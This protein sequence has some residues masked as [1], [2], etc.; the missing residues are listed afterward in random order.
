MKDEG[1]HS[2]V[3]VASGDMLNVEEASSLFVPSCPA[4]ERGWKP[5]LRTALDGHE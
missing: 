3:L 1:N 4:Q 2:V 5:R